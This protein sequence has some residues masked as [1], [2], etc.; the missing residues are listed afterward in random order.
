MKT[1]DLSLLSQTENSY[2][3]ALLS[4]KE[5]YKC[6]WDDEIHDSFSVF[7]SQIEENVN[8]IHLAV[9]EIDLVKHSVHDI[10]TE[11]LCKTAESVYREAES[12]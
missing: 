1:V 8:N 6:N 10:N 7:I 5:K 12:V 4:L 11:D 9:S 2:K 3:E